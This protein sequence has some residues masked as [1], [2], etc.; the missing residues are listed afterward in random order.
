MNDDLRSQTE[1]LSGSRRRTSDARPYNDGVFSNNA[2]VGAAI[3][4]PPVEIRSDVK[5]HASAKEII[6]ITT[7][8]ASE[9]TII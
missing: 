6:A 2:A 9:I 1:L 8:R 3:G 4:R 5:Q 7:G